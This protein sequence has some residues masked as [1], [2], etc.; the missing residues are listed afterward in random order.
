MFKPEGQIYIF[1]NILYNTPV[2]TA[3]ITYNYIFFIKFS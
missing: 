2:S 1:P 3:N